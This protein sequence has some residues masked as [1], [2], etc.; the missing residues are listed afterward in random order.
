MPTELGN[1]YF[2][3]V[4]Q[5]P[6]LQEQEEAANEYRNETRFAELDELVCEKWN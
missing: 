1:E 5:I 4:W 6:G 3:E 2:A